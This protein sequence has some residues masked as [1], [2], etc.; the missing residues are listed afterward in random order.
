MILGRVS[1]RNHRGANQHSR[2]PF[3]VF[4]R[5]L[6]AQSH[7]PIGSDDRIVDLSCNQICRPS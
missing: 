3:D 7:T 5:V 2:A 1:R 6:Q 4:V